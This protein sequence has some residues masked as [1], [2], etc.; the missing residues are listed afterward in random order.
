MYLLL[1]YQHI[2]WCFFS[3]FAIYFLYGIRNS[4]EGFPEQRAQRVRAETQKLP[5]MDD[6][7]TV[8][9]GGLTNGV[10]TENSPLLS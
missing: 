9:N 3:G 8:K 6:T 5:S 1:L 7:L 2:L 10:K 4:V